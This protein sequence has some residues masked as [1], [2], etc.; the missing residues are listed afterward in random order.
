MA[1]RSATGQAPL[2]RR[3]AR[4]A[5]FLEGCSLRG[6]LARLPG[7]GY[8]RSIAAGIRGQGEVNNVWG[9]LW[10][11]RRALLLSVLASLWPTGALAVDLKLT[12]F[13]TVGYAQSDASARYLRYIDKDGTFKADSL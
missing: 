8:A 5:A 3:E 7:K 12:G 11:L 13:G 4:G 6:A 10:R 9:N 2:A 1:S